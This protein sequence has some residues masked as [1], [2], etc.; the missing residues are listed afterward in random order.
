MSITATTLSGAVAVGDNFVGVASATG[1]SA[2]TPQTGANTTYL[3]VDDEMMYVVSVTGTQIGVL[4][5]QLGTQVSAHESSAP[6]LS[7]APSDF[8]NFVPNVASF[9]TKLPY[10]FTPIGAPL[11]GATIAPLYGFVHHFTGTTALVTI[12]VPSGLVSGGKVTIVFDGS[13]SGLTWTAADNIAV[14][15]TATTAASSVD[16]FYNPATAKWIPSRLA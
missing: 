16:F 3:K 15:G 1:I 13:G 11:T 7:G 4:R 2:P 9:A 12:T 8:P 5:G 14:A 10:N 6:V